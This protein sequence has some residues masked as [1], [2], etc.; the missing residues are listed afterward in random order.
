MMTLRDGDDRRV[1]QNRFPHRFSPQ[2]WRA[3][4]AEMTDAAIWPANE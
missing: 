3:L 4:K 2:R 1:R